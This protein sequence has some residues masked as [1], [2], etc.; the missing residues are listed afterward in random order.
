[1]LSKACLVWLGSACAV[2][3]LGLAEGQRATCGCCCFDLLCS[4]AVV[5]TKRHPAR[6]QEFMETLKSYMRLP[7]ERVYLFI[8]LDHA[9]KS[10]WNEF[11]SQVDTMFGEKLMALRPYRW[12]NQ[13]E[14]RTVM[15][16][17]V[18]PPNTDLGNA[19][20][21]SHRLIWF[22]QNDD[23]PFIDIDNNV[24]C[25]GIGLLR[26]SG[27]RFKSLYPS[28]F[29]GALRL[30]GLKGEGPQPLRVGKGYVTNNITTL[31]G[32]QIMNLGYLRYILLDLDW[33]GQQFR[34]IDDLIRQRAIYGNASEDAWLMS[35]DE[36]IST[37]FVP[38]RE[39]CR[40]FDS[41]VS[42][43]PYRVNKVVP[44][45]PRLTVPLRRTKVPS[46]Y[47]LTKRMTKGYFWGRWSQGDNFTVPSDWID[48]SLELYTKPLFLDPAACIL[49][50]GALRA[51]A[52]LP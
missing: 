44:Y 28:S 7:L 47:V 37:L 38:L 6:F 34:R 36:P 25:E 24:F 40:H 12:T 17:I 22:L 18:A 39:L 43:Q 27:A 8:E 13:S 16:K 23:H 2:P 49:S 3:T 41:Y 51:P 15:Q 1:M 20:A 31:D 19:D 33:K 32:I 9:Y 5:Q 42:S 4:V 30:T 48:T 29:G 45:Y 21:D 14:W 50:E 10:L 52:F 46:R 11:E 35:L 26:K